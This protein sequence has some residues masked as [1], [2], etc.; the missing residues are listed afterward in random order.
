M[1]SILNALNYKFVWNDVSSLLILYSP[2]VAALQ[3]SS[4]N[5]PR[6]QS[7][8]GWQ[9]SHSSFLSQCRRLSASVFLFV[10]TRPHNHKAES[11]YCFIPDKL[12]AW[13]SFS[14]KVCRTYQHM[15]GCYFST[16]NMRRNYSWMPR[17]FILHQK[18]QRVWCNSLHFNSSIKSH[19]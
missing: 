8:W 19:S 9:R 3:C 14:Q 7:F 18:C 15:G 12:A 16:A 10:V 4:W 17:L 11:D 13:E 2:A 6:T 1:S 5:K